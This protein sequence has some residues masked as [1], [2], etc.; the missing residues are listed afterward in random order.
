[1]RAFD[2]A[3]AFERRLAEAGFVDVRRDT[4]DGWQRDVVHTWVARR[5]A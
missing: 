5:P 4:M 2:G 3:R 1:V